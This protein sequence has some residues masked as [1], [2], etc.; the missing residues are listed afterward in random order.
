MTAIEDDLGLDQLTPK[1]RECL[2]LVLE[3]RSSKDIGRRLGISHTSVDTHIR[4]A[5]AKLGLR[6]RYVAAEA[7]R[8]WEGGGADSAAAVLQ[9]APRPQRKA[10]RADGSLPVRALIPPMETLSASQTVF[11][12]LL[13]ATFMAL[14]FGIVVN[15]LTT[16]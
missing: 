13:A 15:V 3:N 4:R 16:L 11:M 10:V 7:V 2:R 6:D 12:V 5:R 9:G 1:E 8:A 14:L